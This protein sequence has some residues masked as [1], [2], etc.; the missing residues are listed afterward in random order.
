MASLNEDDYDNARAIAQRMSKTQHDLLVPFTR[1][2]RE[3]LH[4]PGETGPNRYVSY[5]PVL[6]VRRYLCAAVLMKE[7]AALTETMLFKYGP[8][9]EAQ[10]DAMVRQGTT[11]DLEVVGNQ[12]NLLRILSGGFLAFLKDV[13]VICIKK[14]CQPEDFQQLENVATRIHQLYT[15]NEKNIGVLSWK[16]F[17]KEEFVQYIEQCLETIFDK[18]RLFKS[19][20]TPSGVVFQGIADFALF[21]GDRVTKPTDDPVQYLHMFVN[22][23]GADTTSFEQTFH[24]RT[25]QD[26]FIPVKTVADTVGDVVHKMVEFA[27]RVNDKIPMGMKFSDGAFQFQYLGKLLTSYK[28]YVASINRMR[29]SDPDI[30]AFITGKADLGL[31]IARR[32]VA[33]ADTR[34][35]HLLYTCG[36]C[37]MIH[38][39]PE[40]G[41]IPWLD[42]GELCGSC[43][44][45]IYCNRDCQIKA[46][47]K[48][49]KI[50][51]KTH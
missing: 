2:E 7:I 39:P 25:M 51:K 21:H 48:H 30:F 19:E 4:A 11:M 42:R 29:E 38:G 5:G 10:Y 45:V 13:L 46:W 31:L 35:A 44:L 16:L 43:N 14:D 20:L 28:D 12:I 50:C 17:N 9:F 32:I 18:R 41:R 1:L 40:L 22:R 3:V 36:N 34:S 47:R 23:N 24:F 26:V 6:F 33:S 15:R 27:R 8:V 37:G 49:Q